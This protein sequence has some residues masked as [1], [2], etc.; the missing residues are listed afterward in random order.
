MVIRK[1][2]VKIHVNRKL[3]NPSWFTLVGV[4][5]IHSNNVV[6]ASA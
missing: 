1:V 2:A 5:T 3:T 6:E 4:Q